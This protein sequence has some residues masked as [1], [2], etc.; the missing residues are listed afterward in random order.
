MYL[1]L[2]NLS[3]RKQYCHNNFKTDLINSHSWII[4]WCIK[5][6]QNIY[7]TISFQCS[8]SAKMLGFI[9]E[10]TTKSTRFGIKK[11]RTAVM[12]DNSAVMKMPLWENYI[13]KF[14]TGKSY[15]IT[16]LLTSNFHGKIQLSTTSTTKFQELEEPLNDVDEKKSRNFDWC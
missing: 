13:T 15:S 14:E 3:I 10:E 16:N 2:Y 9:D 5:F 8:I 12:G 6:E 7:P 11:F 1:F 4:F